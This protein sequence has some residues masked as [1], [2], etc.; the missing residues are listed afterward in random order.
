MAQNR[1]N[2]KPWDHTSATTKK[3]GQYAADR[4]VSGVF[5]CPLTTKYHSPKGHFFPLSNYSFEGSFRVV[6]R[7]SYVVFRPKLTPK[8]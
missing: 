1:A 3:L 4:M 7:K 2:E 5:L 8:P 6:S